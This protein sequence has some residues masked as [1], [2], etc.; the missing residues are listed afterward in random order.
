[1]IFDLD[2]DWNVGFI[3]FFSRTKK[4][5]PSNVFILWILY[6]FKFSKCLCLGVRYNQV[7]KSYWTCMQ[8]PLWDRG[9]FNSVRYFLLFHPV[10]VWVG[11]LSANCGV[12]TYISIHLGYVRNAIVRT[13]PPLAPTELETGYKTLPRIWKPPTWSTYGIEDRK[14]PLPQSR[15]P[16]S[17]YSAFEGQVCID[18]AAWLF[19][20]SQL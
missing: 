15:L 9:I 5:H 12:L 19:H 18:R 7:L 14:P 20:T 6:S 10:S 16:C 4:V 17:L 11:V 13:A 1:M 8:F 3:D 2:W